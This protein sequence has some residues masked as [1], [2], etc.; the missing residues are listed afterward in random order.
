MS[1]SCQLAT[2]DLP[3]ASEDGEAAAPPPLDAGPEVDTDC[4][5]CTRA[6]LPD[7]P[8]CSG[9]VAFKIPALNCPE[10]CPGAAAYA[11][12]QG[13][14]Y[15]ACACTLP[16]GYTLIDGGF[17][18]GEAGSEDAPSHKDAAPDKDGGKDAEKDVTSAKDTGAE[19]G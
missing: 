13:G 2:R 7:L 19:G 6:I 3:D 18:I 10:S 4:G 9:E 14:C 8:F 5:C 11:L 12:C 17:L 16:S 15:T 1:S